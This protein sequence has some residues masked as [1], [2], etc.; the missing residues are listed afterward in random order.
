LD[1]GIF[2]HLNIINK[3]LL[4]IHTN[5]SFINYFIFKM[6]GKLKCKR[7]HPE[8]VLP[9]RATKKAAGYDLSSVIDCTVPARGKFLVPTG[10]AIRVPEG[11]YGRIAPRSSLSWKNHT[12]LGAG[13]LDEDYS[14]QV[15]VIIFNHAETDLEI[16]KGDRIAQLILE[17]IEIPE[18]EEVVE[19]DET[20]R[21]EGGFGSTGR[22]NEKKEEKQEEKEE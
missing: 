13:V 3:T 7:L 8:A 1:E 14:G 2:S 18:S 22:G 11:T 21:G 10:W 17:K 9:Y 12:D 20:E 5:E 16:K 15:H 6:V 19:L 4:I